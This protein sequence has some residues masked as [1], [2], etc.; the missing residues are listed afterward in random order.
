MDLEEGSWRQ[1]LKLLRVLN[2]TFWEGFDGLFVMNK[3][4]LLDFKKKKKSGT[5]LFF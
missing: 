5:S 4:L 2:K 3:A 1:H